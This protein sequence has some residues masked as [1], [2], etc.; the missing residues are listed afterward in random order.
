MP[1]IELENVRHVFRVTT[2]TFRRRSREVLALDG[3]SMQIEAGELF[4]FLGPNGAGKTATIK[5]L[6]TLLIPTSGRAT[7]GQAGIK[8]F[9]VG[10][11]ERAHGE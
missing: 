9:A 1:A 5:V 4:G 3:V 10:L 11:A 8:G 7:V 2:G 6:A